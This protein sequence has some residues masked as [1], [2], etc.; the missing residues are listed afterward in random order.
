MIHCYVYKCIAPALYELPHISVLLLHAIKFLNFS[1]WC[2]TGG[3]TIKCDNFK[4]F[5]VT[6]ICF[7]ICYEK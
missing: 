3:L 5:D 4:A 1:N 7:S 2:S 6:T